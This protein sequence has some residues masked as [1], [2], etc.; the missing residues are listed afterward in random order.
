MTPISD[1]EQAQVEG[2]ATEFQSTLVQVIKTILSTP[3][4]H[5]VPGK[6]VVA[7]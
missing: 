3:P 1:G 2:G 5:P 7:K 6:P 4:T